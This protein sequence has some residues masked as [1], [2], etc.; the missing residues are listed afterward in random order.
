[1]NNG[2]GDVPFLQ[3][4]GY[5][6]IAVGLSNGNS[7]FGPTIAEGAGR[8][9]PDLVVPLD[10][11]SFATPVVSASAALL[12]ETASA[13]PDPGEASAAGRV[14]TI[15]AALLSG[16]TTSPFSGLA[17]PWHRTNNGA[18]VE[19]LDRRFGAGQLNIDNSHRIISAS[20]QD[21][22]DLIRD[23]PTG[24]DFGSLS[25]EV[26]TR[27]YFFDA[28]SD[29]GSATLAATVTWLR[30]I[31]QSGGDFTTQTATLA[32]IELR[33]YE[34]DGNLNLGEL[35]D[36][37]LSPVDNVQHTRT[38]LLPASHY[39]V[40]VSLGGLPVG[41]SIE[42]FA[43]AWQVT[44][45]PVPE[46]RFV[47]LILAAMVACVFELNHPRVRRS[48]RSLSPPTSVRR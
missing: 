11:T 1:M 7:S 13:K 42:D 16:A 46:P 38:S 20:R 22:T 43:I 30:R 45:T 34:T 31:P 24:W 6:S 3:A 21:G 32:D 36:S 26:P 5:N 35:I 4:S 17:D 14:E 47:L 29:V 18:F 2:P 41:Q 19:P 40:E 23:A 48:A 9:K 44:V 37:S 12:V 28:P 39:A 10:L 33:I 15:K 27:R 25:M 8:S